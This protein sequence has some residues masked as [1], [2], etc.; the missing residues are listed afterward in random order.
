MGEVTAIAAARP[1]QTVFVGVDGR[2]GAGKSTLAEAIAAAAPGSVV[3]HVDD[4]AG[5][6]VPEWDWPRLRE[7]VLLPLLAGRPGRYQR[8]E[9]NRDQPAEWLDVPTGRL[10]I[11]EGVSSTRAEVGVPWTVQIWVDAPREVRLARAVERDG[12]QLLPQ[13]LDVWMPAEEAYIV[14]DRPQQRADL[15]VDGTELAG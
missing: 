14:R 3:V 15:I 6:L 10:V 12:R 1:A 8:W 13:W 11:I 9:W 4:F 7:Q 5:P 2:A